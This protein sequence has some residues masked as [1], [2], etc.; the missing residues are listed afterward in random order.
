MGGGGS[1]CFIKAY[2][3]TTGEELQIIADSSVPGF[4]AIK[5]NSVGTAI[6]VTGEV[7]PSKGKEQKASQF[8]NGF[9]I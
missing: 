9:L 3:G 6:F 2:D 4:D 8:L 5:Q 7:V 1:F